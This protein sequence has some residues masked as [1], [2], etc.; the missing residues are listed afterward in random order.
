MNT[1]L[2]RTLSHLRK[3]RGLTQAEL[4]ERLSVSQPIIA[5]WEN[6]RARPNDNKQYG[7]SCRSFGTSR[8]ALLAGENEPY[9]SLPKVVDPFAC[10]GSSSGQ[11]GGLRCWGSKKC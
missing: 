4:A 3:L 1:S 11:E 8:E 10:P 7:K 5:R 6:G 9:G 2:G